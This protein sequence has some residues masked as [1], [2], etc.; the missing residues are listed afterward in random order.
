MRARGWRLLLWCRRR[1]GGALSAGAGE[2]SPEQLAEVAQEFEALF[3]HQMLRQMR[4]AAR[5]GEDEDGGMF[6]GQL[7]G[8]YVFGNSVLN[9]LE[10]P[11]NDPAKIVIG[12]HETAFQ[13]FSKNAGGGL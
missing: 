1:L 3:I 10:C 12:K 5:W 9:I 4:E 13:V 11:P 7:L 8:E 2:R 6:G